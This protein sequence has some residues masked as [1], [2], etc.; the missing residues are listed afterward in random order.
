VK[1]RPYSF[2]L[3]TCLVLVPLAASAEPVTP[4][5]AAPG[6]A[7]PVPGELLLAAIDVPLSTE[8]V[9]RSGL[10]E[11]TATR[12]LADPT[13]RRYVR[14]RAVSSLPFFGTASA[15]ALVEATL[16]ADADE[17]VRIQAAT[18]LA[19]GFGTADPVG[20]V[21]HLKQ[22]TRGASPAVAEAIAA[23]LARLLPA[24]GEPGPT[25]RVPAP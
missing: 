5:P 19:R 8:L 21:A 2:A 14:L 4:A 12:L 22:A 16:A 13:Q 18:S 9:R 25:T 24:G 15:R 7:A 23:E 6:P 10:T 17:V 3:A 20:V 11:A 1:A